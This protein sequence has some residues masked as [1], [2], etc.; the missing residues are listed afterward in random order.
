[1]IPA[2]A[3]AVLAGVCCPPPSSSFVRADE[4]SLA[5]LVRG[6]RRIVRGTVVRVEELPVAEA[7]LRSPAEQLTWSA[8]RWTGW[9]SIPIAELEIDETYKGASGA[10]TTWFVAAGRSREWRSSRGERVVMF[11]GQ[12]VHF[13]TVGCDA[14]DLARV[15]TG[16]FFVEDVAMNGCGRFVQTFGDVPMTRFPAD[17]ILPSAVSTAPS[18]DGIGCDA[19]W[20]SLE[21]ALREIVSAELPVIHVHDPFEHGVFEPCE[22]FIYG[23]RRLVLETGLGPR[24][25]RRVLALDPGDLEWI[26]KKME[27]ERFFD[28][29]DEI[30][31]DE[32]PDDSDLRRIEYTTRDRSKR[33]LL[34]NSSRYRLE[35]LREGEMRRALSCILAVENLASRARPIESR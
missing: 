24:E 23:D 27:S 2:L 25:T 19:E 35:D 17:V 12:P 28:L 30:G 29:P 9:T 11:F 14:I 3:V 33:V 18:L 7:F 31:R 22:A 8:R 32:G 21:R 26:Q 1:M 10:K 6:S 4:A 34:W 20:R 15:L 16:D 5:E 13:A